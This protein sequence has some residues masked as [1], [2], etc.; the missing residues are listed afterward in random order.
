MRFAPLAA[1][2]VLALLLAL[3]LWRGGGEERAALL[4]ADAPLAGL[5][6]G[7]R[8]PMVVNF[9]A[10]WCLPCAAEQPVLE[11]MAREGVR[12]YGIAYKDKEEA[13]AAWLEKHGDPYAAMTHDPEGRAAVEW[14]I[15]GV[16]ETFVVGRDG[17][18]VYKYAGPLTMELYEGEIRKLAGAEG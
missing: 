15:T 17:K 5:P 8:G 9:F 2:F 18:I 12:V 3:A 1:F 14:G 13:V 11:R 4:H 6:E 10:S 16:P 7:A